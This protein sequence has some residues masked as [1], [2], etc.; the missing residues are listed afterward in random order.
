MGGAAMKI[1]NLYAGIGGNRAQWGTEHE[2]T[3][4]EY[5]PLIAEV[6]HDLFPDDIVVVG[7]AMAYLE[8][9]YHEYD[10]IWLSPP[11]PTHGQYRYNVGVK[12]KGYA[13]VIPEMTSLYGAIVFLDHHFDG[14]YAV[15]N[16]IPYYKPLIEPT[17][18]LQR[19]YIW[20]NF[21]ITEADF[22]AKGLR[23]KN[24]LSD[25]AAVG[26]DLSKTKIKNKRQVFR[27][28]ADPRVGRHVLDAAL[29]ER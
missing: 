16:V 25:Y 3:A 13:P 4:V 24:K 27:N 20:S 6:Y 22:D 28:M 23:D 2:V 8:A 10:F 29:A 21:P 7:D 26:I 5:D 9:H 12:A 14:L 15:E 1:L 18:K 17:V 11:C 19:H